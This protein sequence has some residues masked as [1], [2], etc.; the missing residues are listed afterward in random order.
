MVSALLQI[1]NDR[2]EVAFSSHSGHVF[3]HVSE[4]LEMTGQDQLMSPSHMLTVRFLHLSVS[5]TW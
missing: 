2:K 1:V 3:A 5:L 4:T